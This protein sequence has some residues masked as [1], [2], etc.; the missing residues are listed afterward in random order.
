VSELKHL[1]IGLV[2]AAVGAV[3]G[4]ALEHWVRAP[5]LEDVSPAPAAVQKD[6]SVVAERAAPAP[7]SRPPHLL[8][9]GAKEVRRVQVVVQPRE[10]APTPDGRCDPKP[11]EVDMSLVRV[12]GGQR[13]VASTPDG[14]VV[15]ALDLPIEATSVP[16]APHRWA[17]GLSY[18]TDRSPGLWLERDLGRLRVG[19]EVVRQ[20]AGGA[21]ARVR[22]GL[23]W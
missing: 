21:Q 3:G 2:L 17:A 13:V 10:M 7:T 20:P 5:K 6:G 8:P 19:A 18:G 9:K 11:V 15:K 12:D 1:A 4:V 14:T 23:S 16:A 22:V